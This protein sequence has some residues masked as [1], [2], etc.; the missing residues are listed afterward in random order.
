PA[1]RPSTTGRLVI[2]PNACC[3]TGVT[4]CITPGLAP[5]STA[6]T[7]N[8]PWYSCASRPSS[9]TWSRDSGTCSAQRTSTAGTETVPLTTWLKVASVASRTSPLPAPPPGD[10]AC[11]PAAG[12]DRPVAPGRP[13]PERADRSTAPRRAEGLKGC[14]LMDPIV[15]EPGTSCD[16]PRSGALGADDLLV[17]RDE[18]RG[19][20]LG[21]D[22]HRGEHQPVDLCR[23]G[24]RAVVDEHPEGVRRAQLHA[25]AHPEH[26]RAVEHTEGDGRAVGQL[27]GGEVLVPVLVGLPERGLLV[28]LGRLGARLV[29]NLRGVTAGLEV[30]LVLG[31]RVVED[32]AQLAHHGVRLE[33]QL[34]RCLRVEDR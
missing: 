24:D 12:A 22:V 33:P 1:S 27:D 19:G 30:G 32:P 18:A 16:A 17:H 10:A 7:W 2:W 23:L 26:R 3:R 25:V 9:A 20:A 13:A 34:G 15:P 11:W 5:S 8:R 31:H 28:D 29:A 21:R 4:A 14:W 6:T